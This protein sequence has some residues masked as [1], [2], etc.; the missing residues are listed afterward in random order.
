MRVCSRDHGRVRRALARGG[1]SRREGSAVTL[2]PDAVRTM[3]D[4]IAPVYDAMNRVMTVGPRPRWRRLAA[5]AVVRPGDR[6]LD[7]ACGTGDL[8]LADLRAGA[9]EVDG[10]S[11]SRSGCS[12]ARGARRP[13]RCDVGRRATCSRLPFADARVRRGHGRLRRPQRRRPRAGAARAAPRAPPRRPARDPRDH[14]AARR[15]PAVLLALVRPARAAARHACSRAARRTRTFRRRCAASRR[16][17]ELAALLR[18]GRLRRR[19]ASGC[20]RGSIVALHVG[21]GAR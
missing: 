18:R 14:A 3:F 16:P 9:A 2:A 13:R 6:V 5:A 21:D 19:R 8:A 17:D 20:S 12:S 1:S 15:A 4:R 7:A 11:T 10:R